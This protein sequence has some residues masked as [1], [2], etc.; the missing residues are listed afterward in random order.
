M[1]HSF[2]R[3]ATTYDSVASLQRNVGAELLKKAEQNQVAEVV[4]DL[5]CGTG[6]FTPQLQKIFPKAL[7][8]GVDIAEG[9]L[10]FA[11]EKWGQS[12]L[13]ANDLESDIH[14]S[15][16]DSDPIFACACADAEYLPFANQSVNVIYSNFALQWCGNL[17]RLFA[18]LKRIL[19]PDGQL[20]FTTLGP[21]TLHELKSA[22]QMV[23]NR[24]HVNQFHERDLLLTHLQQ[25]DFVQIEFEHK[26]AVMEFEHLSD[27]TRSL[28]ALGAQNVNRG[29]AAGLT[30]RKKIQAFKQAYEN[31]RSNNLLPATYDVFYVKVKS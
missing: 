13:M 11:R 6:F 12:H 16:N 7:I 17:P 8:V 30:G 1:A 3:A 31:F 5:G 4:I 25:Q 27:L 19:K 23:D 26:P 9:M 15:L 29:R 18:E 24:V 20:I 2:S 28:K 22:W 14:K 21:A 10:Q